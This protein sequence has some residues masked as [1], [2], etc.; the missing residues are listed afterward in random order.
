MKF[1]FHK[2][3]FIWFQIRLSG[4]LS[5]RS[6]SVDKKSLM[7]VIVSDR[8]AAAS[9]DMKWVGWMDY[10]IKGTTQKLRL[11][12]VCVRFSCC[13]ELYL[14]FI[15]Q[16][17]YPGDQV[18][19][20]YSWWC[21]VCGLGLLRLPQAFW[22]L[23]QAELFTEMLTGYPAGV[24]IEYPCS[25]WTSHRLD[26]CGFGWNGSGKREEDP[27]RMQIGRGG[28]GGAHRIWLHIKSYLN[29]CSFP[30]WKH[31]IFSTH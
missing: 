19:P 9:C 15:Y 7:Y 13:V 27:T 17:N 4:M 28:L 5:I 16:W 23:T 21:G 8:V 22:L 14:V 30:V 20:I 18:Q 6:H 29:S 31:R 12:F 25:H 11:V 3:Q 24:E 26:G 2:R 1:F 10:S